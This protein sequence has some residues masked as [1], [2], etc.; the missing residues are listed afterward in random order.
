MVSDLRTGELF[1][2]DKVIEGFLG[3]VVDAGEDRRSSVGDWERGEDYVERARSVLG[4]LGTVNTARGFDD[5]VE[6]FGIC[7]PNVKGSKLS[8]SFEFNLMFS[9][10]I[11]AQGNLTGYLRPETAQS[12][13][14]NFKRLLQFNNG[15]LPFGTA[16]IGRSYRNEIAPRGGPLRVRE[17][18]MAEIE[19]FI[20]PLEQTPPDLQPLSHH[21]VSLLSYAD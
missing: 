19:Y 21:Q 12:I 15:Q 1:R 20:D 5:L 16:V 7:N 2:V 6:E 11:G 17:F 14:V 4:S 10:K 9:T 13:F 3:R 18:E 8:K